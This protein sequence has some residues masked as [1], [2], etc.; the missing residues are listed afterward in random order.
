MKFFNPPPLRLRLLVPAVALIVATTMIPTALRHP[1]LLYIDND[2]NPADAGNNLLLYMPLGFAL[3]GS[4]LLRAFLFGLGLSASAELLQLGYVDRIPSLID[5]ASNTCGAVVGY[6]LARLWIRATGHNLKFLPLGR[7]AG[8][9]ALAMAVAGS[10]M[11]IHRRPRYDFS[12]WN[13][14]FHLA[15]G[16]E[17]TGNRP[18]AGNVTQFQVYPFAIAPEVIHE[19]ALTAAPGPSGNQPTALPDGGLL[20]PRDVPLKNGRPL[21]SAL[22]ERTL[23]DTLVRSS[24]LTLLVW[25][26][27]ANVEQSGPARVITYSQDSF[28]RNFT[29]GQIHD[30][31]TF[32]LRTPDSGGNGTNP[33]LYSGPVLSADHTS[34][35]AAVYDGRHSTLYVD[36]RQVA[37]ADLGASRP[38]LPRRLLAWLPGSIPVHEIETVAAEI[39]LS[40]LF[41][42]GLF[43]LAGVPARRSTLLLAALA[44]G[45]ALG[46][47]LWALDVSSPWLGIR[48]LAECAAAGLVVAA[49]IPGEPLV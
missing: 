20:P 12:N 49:S 6:L 25:M 22:Q 9:A 14:A 21:S 28:N 38:R 47:A 3:G 44:A 43:G 27:P 30:T 8:A 36:G 24:R 18:W 4:S 17:I 23:F 35:V 1:S 48:I 15:I 26:R 46:A 7:L 37:Q 45:A 16:N 40:G 41:T 32:R 10:L 34:F 11:L 13:P 33:A 29:L 39:L 19:L 2:L 31:L 42:L 5:V